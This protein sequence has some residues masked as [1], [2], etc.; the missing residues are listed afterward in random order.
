VNAR[1]ADLRANV[2]PD[3]L[4]LRLAVFGYSSG[5]EYLVVGA[6]DHRSISCDFWNRLDV[7]SFSGW[8]LDG[9]RIPG[10]DRSYISVLGRLGAP[11]KIAVEAKLVAHT[12]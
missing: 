1:E 10:G 6:C 9:G 2:A 12:G 8:A 7:C 3:H 4:L 11:R 5:H